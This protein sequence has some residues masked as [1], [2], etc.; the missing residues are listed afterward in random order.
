MLNRTKYHCFMFSVVFCLFHSELSISGENPAVATEENFD[1]KEEQH[2]HNRLV[3]AMHEDPR[4]TNLEK[5]L[6][7]GN[8]PV[9][10]RGKSGQTPLMVA[11]SFK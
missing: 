1:I 3:N 2:K 5:L 10:A 7:T 9:D 6:N 11:E 8:L 4:G